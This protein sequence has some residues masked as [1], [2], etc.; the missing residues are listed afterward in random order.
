L[1]L[2]DGQI[3]AT[4]VGVFVGLAESAAHGLD[5]LFI[6]DPTQNL[7]LPCKEAVAKLMVE[8]AGRKQIIVSTHDEDFVSYLK[9]YGFYKN[10]SVFHIESWNGNPKIVSGSKVS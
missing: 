6:D 4:A 9:E 5:L 10:A 8:M 1:V 3:T 2:S 7:D